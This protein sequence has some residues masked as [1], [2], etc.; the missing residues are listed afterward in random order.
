MG[1]FVTGRLQPVVNDVIGW[2]GACWTR[3]ELVG[4]ARRQRPRVAEL[5]FLAVVPDRERLERRV[6]GLAMQEIVHPRDVPGNPLRMVH[7]ETGVPVVV[8]TLPDM[9]AWATQVVRL[10]GG[11]RFIRRVERAAGRQRWRIHWD[12]GTVRKTPQRDTQHYL[13]ERGLLLALLGECPPPEAR[14]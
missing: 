1:R 5:E 7:V 11:E 14:P 13:T 10:T 6:C 2:C 12:R 9:R 3:V 4:G 8:H